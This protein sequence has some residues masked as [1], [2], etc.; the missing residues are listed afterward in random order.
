MRI[1]VNVPDPVAEEAEEV[2]EEAGISLSALFAQAVESY[3]AR[4]RRDRAIERINALIGTGR[5]TPDALDELARG[6]AASDRSRG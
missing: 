2:A 5:V 3:L 4:R 6:R 1:T